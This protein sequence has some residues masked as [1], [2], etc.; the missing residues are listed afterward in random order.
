[1]LLHDHKLDR[2]TYLYPSHR[3]PIKPH[4]LQGCRCSPQRRC[5]QKMQKI[6]KKSDN[7]KKDGMQKA[8]KPKAK[9]KAKACE[10]KHESEGEGR[11]G[12]EA[13][14][15]AVASDLLAAQPELVTPA[16]RPWEEIVARFVGYYRGTQN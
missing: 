15:A 5:E 14:A 11:D 1:M 8:P 2:M 10:P 12:A 3:Y 7:V 16:G 13:A 9:A 6:Q 4:S